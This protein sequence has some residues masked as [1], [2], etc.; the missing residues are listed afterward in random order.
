MSNQLH[1][2]LQEY[3]E[4]TIQAKEKL[5]GELLHGDVEDVEEH[6]G[7]TKEQSDS[8]EKKAQ[9][10]AYDTVSE[11]GGNHKP[12]DKSFTQ[13]LDSDNEPNKERVG[14]SVSEK[15]AHDYLEGEGTMDIVAKYGISTS[16]LYNCLRKEGVSTR[17]RSITE[18]KVKEIGTETAK[19]LIMDY[20]VNYMTVRDICQ[21]YNIDWYTLDAVLYHYNIDKN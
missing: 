17:H 7:V 1:N 12:R 2:A 9:E 20:K 8:L 3:L 10:S 16:T 19:R 6:V 21:K 5:L 14:T 15:V 13:F 11:L 18:D 4:T